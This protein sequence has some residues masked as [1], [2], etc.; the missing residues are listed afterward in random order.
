MDT[1]TPIAR[2]RNEAHPRAGTGE[3]PIEA[4]RAR[5]TVSRCSR[6]DVGFREVYVSVDAERIAVLQAGESVTHDLPAGRHRL[7][8]DNTLFART[9]EF[10]LKPGEHRRFRAINRAGWGHSLMM[11]LGAGLLYL[12]LEPES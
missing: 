12:T 4:A 11:I 8:A 2:D 6:E 10:D 1:D 7:R 5:I 9:Q 3:P